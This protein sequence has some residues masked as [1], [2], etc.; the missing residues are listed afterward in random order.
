MGI[1]DFLTG[2]NAYGDAGNTLSDYYGQAMG[3][4]QPYQ[5]AGQ[6]ALAP[7]MQAGQA[8]MNPGQLE[9]QWMQSYNESPMAQQEQLQARQQGMGLAESMGLGQST[10]AMQAVNQSVSNIGA[11]DRNTFMD[12]MMQKYLAG[13]GIMQ[14][15]YGTGANAS[16]VLAQLLAQ[17]AGSQANMTYGQE[18]AGPSMLGG[19]VGTL[20]GSALGPIGSA[21][22]GA[23]GKKI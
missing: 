21:I 12:N 10:P 6:N 13:T 14:N 9:N 1:F 11:Q 23:I 18:E 15:I 19:L 4:L 16:N 2:A 7:Y 8:L 22:G 5:Q 17:E 20:A 3:Q